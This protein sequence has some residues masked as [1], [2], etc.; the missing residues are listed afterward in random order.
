MITS[1]K[2]I[3]MNNHILPEETSYCQEQKELF[4]YLI[5]SG[6]FY[7]VTENKTGEKEIRFKNTV[8]VS[9]FPGIIRKVPQL[10]EVKFPDREQTPY[11]T[12]NLSKLQE[13]LNLKRPVAVEGGP[14]L[15]GA[16]EV[17]VEIIL[18]NGEACFLIIVR[19]KGTARVQRF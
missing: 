5:V 6:D 10:A 14:C 15:F 8:D 3:L 2:N 9:D 12:A 16:H 19:E 1:L 13:A 4:D 17:E 7:E 11:F 18:Q